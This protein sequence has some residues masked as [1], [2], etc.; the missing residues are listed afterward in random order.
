MAG[1]IGMAFDKLLEARGK[2]DVI[3]NLLSKLVDMGDMVTQEDVIKAASKIVASG[4][5]A[6]GVAAMLADMPEKGELL[7]PWLQQHKEQIDAK[8]Q[9]LTQV[10]ED[11]RHHMGVSALQQLLQGQEAPS[12]ASGNELGIAAGASGNGPQNPLAMEQ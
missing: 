3:Q 7:A 1:D 9:Q 11:V 2:M 8:E 12:E 6:K 4:V 10:T 5:D